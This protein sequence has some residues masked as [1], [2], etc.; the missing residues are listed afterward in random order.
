MEVDESQ[1][2]YSCFRGHS[3]RV[4]TYGSSL[5]T[6]F[7]QRNDRLHDVARQSRTGHATAPRLLGQKVLNLT[8]I[9]D[10]IE[11]RWKD[12]SAL[13]VFMPIKP[14]TSRKES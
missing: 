14:P 5:I 4:F 13:R 10:F 7:Q 1:Q 8:N 9:F 11:S 12:P 3:V 6:M 2:N